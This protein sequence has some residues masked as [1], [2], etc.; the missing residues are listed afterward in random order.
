VPDTRPRKSVRPALEALEDRWAPAV[1]TVNTLADNTTDTSHLTLRAAVTLV[2][3][4]GNPGSLG[5][6]S[7]PAGWASQVSGAF[8]QKDTIQF[9][10]G[11]LTQNIGY[12]S[13]VIGLTTIGDSAAGYSALRVSVPVS[14]IGPTASPG[15]TIA[16]EAP[17]T[18]F[19]LFYVDINGSLT[20]DNL[21]LSGGFAQG[22]AGASG[23]GGAGL[24]GALFNQGGNVIIT[25]ST[26]A[27]NTAQGGAGG[28]ATAGA[29]QGL[30]GAIFNR[31]GAVTLTNSTLSG[32]LA[33]QGGGGV[34]TLGDGAIA[35]VDLLNSIVANSGAG[36]TDLRSSTLGGGTALVDGANSL[37]GAAATGGIS[38]SNNLVGA[39]ASPVN[40]LL[41]PLQNN[42]GPTRTF[43]PLPG[44]PAIDAGNDFFRNDVASDERVANATDQTGHPRVFG[45]HIDIGAVGNCSVATTLQ[46]APVPGFTAGH[47]RTIQVKILDQF[48]NLLANDNTDQVTLSGAPF[49]SGSATATVQNG[50]ATFANL[51]IDAAGAYTLAASSGNLTPA[52][53]SLAVVPAATSQFAV[54]GLWQANSATG[55]TTL[56]GQGLTFTGGDTVAL[57]PNLI[58]NAASLSVDVTFR[59]TQGGVILGYQ[60]QPPGTAPSNYVPALYVGG[61]GRLYA[62][63]W[64]GA[65]QPLQSAA[66][67][68][69]GATHEA[70]LSLWGDTQTLKL[71]NTLVGTLT[72]AVQPLDMAFDQLGAGYT[73]SWPAGNGG[74]DPFVDTLDKLTISTGTP[75]ATFALSG[76]AGVAGTLTVAAEDAFGNLTPGYTGM[77]RFSSSDPKAVLAATAMLSHGVGVFSA[78]LETA[79]TQSVTATDTAQATI[80]GREAGITV[81]PA[82]PAS[83]AFLTQPS[84]VVA[85]QAISPA[86]RVELLD[87]FGNLATNSGASVTLSL[88]NNP[89]GATLGGTT[90]LN[91]VQGVATFSTL[92]LDKAGTGYTLRAASGALAAQST[93][94]NVTAAAP[95]G[96]DIHAQPTDTAVG[97]AIHPAVTVNVV[98]AYGN[99]VLDSDQAVTLGI[100]SG[101]AGA[102]LGGT[103]TVRAVHGVATFRDLTLNVAGDYPLTAT[104]GD[105]A[106]DTSNRFTVTPADVTG[107]LQV[108]RG[109]PHRVGGHGD[110]VA[111]EQTL[112]L[113]N[114]SGGVLAGPLAVVLGGLP[115]GFTLANA[116]GTYQG[117]PYMDVLG[118]GAALAPRQSITVTL[119][120]L[121]SGHHRDRDDLNYDLDVLE[122]I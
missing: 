113:T 12:G 1:L 8:G 74:F 110:P 6:S 47:A 48:G 30:G 66:R 51:V 104:G 99:T 50:V 72:G 10:P 101:P 82:A 61:D 96:V 57:P 111:F 11:L 4:A 13:G 23:G 67:V 2:N 56:T 84:N 79:G 18:G 44:S 80:T 116:T 33:A 103:T 119:T 22:G 42:G 95:A 24:G 19:R 53:S 117:H 87:A 21:T 55:Q 121:I 100:A 14:I 9:D 39:V 109:R 106:P 36:L 77:V 68:N 34:Y 54:G 83:V 28:L 27:A 25:N 37:V 16:R 63:F 105:L 78:T 120:L 115:D 93:A 73:N 89:G 40:P 108:D 76:T 86:V 122:G 92:T 102:V 31:N 52:Q 26:L 69:D 58:H 88:A 91:A 32:N 118:S 98:D 65:V 97:Q 7:L 70:V 62:E 94:F 35:E 43:Y 38:G 45:A 81:L 75:P 17:G 114:T 20:L 112:T 5:Q 29:G 107:E 90:T 64:D 71:D 3:N 85:G 60:N 15:I 59:T 46:F 41:G 49:V